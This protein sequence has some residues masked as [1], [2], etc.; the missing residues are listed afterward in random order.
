MP[1]ARYLILS[2][3]AVALLAFMLNIWSNRWS[4]HE[5][6]MVHVETPD[7]EKNASSVI[8]HT[9]IRSDGW[10]VLPEAR[11]AG[12]GYSGEA[13]VLEVAPGRY[14]FALLKELPSS[15][16]VFFPGEAPVEVVSRMERLRASRTLPSDLY[17]LLVT[18]TDIND[19]ASVR[20]VDPDDLAA[21]FGPGYALKAIT[22]EI[23]DEAVTAG[24][25]KSILGWL[26]PYPETSLVRSNDI[27]N[28]TYFGSSIRNGDF[29]RR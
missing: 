25:V 26:G 11:G 18:F 2:I 12:S 19:P 15:F 10:Y 8:R 28:P 6:I 14:L 4:W 21:A 20:R 3:L 22:L 13:V 23:T 29:I 9:M 17:P 5:K 1:R 16:K 24:R 7:G 27:F